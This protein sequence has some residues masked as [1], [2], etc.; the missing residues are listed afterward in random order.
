M[1][2]VLSFGSEYIH[3]EVVNPPNVYCWYVNLPRLKTTSLSA[4]FNTLPDIN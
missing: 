1:F 4:M 3:G 2:I